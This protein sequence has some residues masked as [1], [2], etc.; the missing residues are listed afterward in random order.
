MI[1]SVLL[2]ALGAL[3]LGCTGSSTEDMGTDACV[4]GPGCMAHA[5]MAGG[6]DMAQ[7]AGDMALPPGADLSGMGDLAGATDGLVPFLG[8]C[9]MN[10]D[11]ESMIC[12]DYP[13]KGGM[14]CTNKCTMMTAAQDCPPPSPGCNNM[15]LCKV[16]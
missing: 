8:P 6:S 7:A 9:T 14:F 13:A 15:G 12:G 1:R 3:P 11:C 10:S 5:D 2:A 16:P 4:M